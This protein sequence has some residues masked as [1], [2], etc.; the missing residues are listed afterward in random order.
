LD[1]D[2][3]EWIATKRRDSTRL[4]YASQLTM[5][6]FLGTFL[7]VRFPRCFVFQGQGVHATCFSPFPGLNQSFRNC[8]GDPSSG[9]ESLAEDPAI[10]SIRG[11]S[12]PE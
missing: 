9:G 2:D 5:V 7:E 12:R 4:G 8:I 11:Q 3:R 6:R 10:L 1:D